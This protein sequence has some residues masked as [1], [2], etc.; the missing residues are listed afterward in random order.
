M[1]DV[2]DPA[3]RPAPQLP[4]RVT[5]PL[6]TLITQQSLDEDYLHVAER[7][8]ATS[9]GPARIRPHR[10]AAVVVAVFGV[11]VTTAAV[12][13]S[14][15]ASVNDA[16]RATLISQIT[17]RR[18]SVSRLQD[19]IVAQRER[20]TRLQDTLARTTSAEQSAITRMRRLEVRTGFV[21]VRGEGVRITIDDPPGADGTEAVRDEDLALLVDG[22]WQAGAE[23][24]SIN[25]QRL[26]ALSAIRNA[27]IAI[28]VNSRP[29]SPPYTVLAIGD[30]R[31]LQANLLDTTHGLAFFDV[32]QQLGFVYELHNEDTL[33]LPAAPERLLR[34]RAAKAGTAADQNNHVDEENTP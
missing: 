12:Q 11:L 20:N 26:T 32:A 1:A 33:S 24:I 7:R 31:T 18:D 17:A 3:V 14:R 5:L 9:P 21:P 2:P 22:L 28:H 27:S 15:N 10:T 13:T 30:T 6:L 16:S 29:I 8:A 25:G 23:A 34:L 19:G 4:A